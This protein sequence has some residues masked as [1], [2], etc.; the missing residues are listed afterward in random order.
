M[1]KSLNCLMSVASTQ[2]P[3]AGMREAV[4]REGIRTMKGV[5]GAD[6]WACDASH[7]DR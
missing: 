3:R 2:H 6:L 1:M 4:K 7:N 5:L